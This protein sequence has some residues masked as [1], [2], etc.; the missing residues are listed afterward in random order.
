QL[1]KDLG[2]EFYVEAL[3]GRKAADVIIEF[4]A[5]KG[6]TQIVLGQS[7]RSRWEE[8]TKGSI[9]NKIMNETQFVDVL[10]VADGV[11]DRD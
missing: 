10:I 2:A 5:K 3:G 6:I 11:D 4:V 8:I 9:I 7:A 1:A